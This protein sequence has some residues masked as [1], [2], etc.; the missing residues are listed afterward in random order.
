V[1]SQFGCIGPAD[2]CAGESDRRL[3]SLQSLADWEMMGMQ[4]LVCLSLSEVIGQLQVSLMDV[5]CELKSC[6][7]EL[8][9]ESM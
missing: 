4:L 3:P 8:E 2:C 5:G 1:L 9:M 7:A 6:L